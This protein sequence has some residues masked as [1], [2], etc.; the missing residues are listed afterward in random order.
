MIRRPA[1]WAF[2]HLVPVA[3][4]RRPRSRTSTKNRSAPCGQKGRGAWR[5]GVHLIDQ[6]GSRSRPGGR[7]RCDLMGESNESRRPAPRRR[8]P[9]ARC[10]TAAQRFFSALLTE[11]FVQQ[12][13]RGVTVSEA[14]SS[15]S[16]GTMRRCFLVRTITSR[17]PPSGLRSTSCLISVLDHH[18]VVWC[19]RHPRQSW[20]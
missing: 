14:P 3:S 9:Q 5:V 13:V 12:P 17:N 15:G 19:S 20:R 8:G 18:G 16:A 10:P 4:R 1:A 11:Q 6:P 2:R 7:L